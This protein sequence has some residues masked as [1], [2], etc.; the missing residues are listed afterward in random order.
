MK[1]YSPEIEDV[2]GFFRCNY[3]SDRFKRSDGYQHPNL[4]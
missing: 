4:H 2:E 1:T 3:P